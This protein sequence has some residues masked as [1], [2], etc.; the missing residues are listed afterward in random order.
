MLHGY[1]RARSS[2]RAGVVQALHSVTFPI[3]ADKRHQGMG[4][5]AVA[6]DEAEVEALTLSQAS[7][8]MGVLLDAADSHLGIVSTDGSPVA[9]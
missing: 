8:L 5:I 9:P 1:G 4:Q 7:L 3:L 6:D 2:D